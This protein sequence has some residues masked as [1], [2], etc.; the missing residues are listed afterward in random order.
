MQRFSRKRQAIYDCLCSADNHPT[1]AWIYDR[2][3]EAL[4]DLSLATVYRNLAQLKE[5]GLIGSVG[6]V[7]GYERFD[8]NPVPHAHVICNACGAILDVTDL[9]PSRMFEQVH[10]QTGY[11]ISGAALR[12]TGI[13]PACQADH[14][15]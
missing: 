8:G 14:N 11:E 12:F 1:S 3:S 9:E 13:C 10:A 7:D 15:S 2:L 4:P 6:I 5:A